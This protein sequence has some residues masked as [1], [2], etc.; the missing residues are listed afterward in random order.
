M[1]DLGVFSD[2]GLTRMLVKEFMEGHD[3]DF[4]PE[5][6]EI[7]TKIKNLLGDYSFLEWSRQK[8]KNLFIS[9]NFRGK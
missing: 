2:V 9:V 1:K 7:I 6:D 4:I 8:C 5:H 3:E